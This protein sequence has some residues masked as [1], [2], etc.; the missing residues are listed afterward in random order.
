MS[1]TTHPDAVGRL[2]AAPQL[3]A[4]A[5]TLADKR[6]ATGS[7]LWGSSVAAVVAA[8]RQKL[9]RPIVLVC[10]HLDEADDLADDVELFLGTRPDVVP[11]LE[12]GGSLGRVSEEQ[13]SNRLKLV[14]RLAAGVG[15]T[16]ASPSSA[17]AKER[18]TQVS[19][20]LV[21]PIQALMQAVPAKSE[22]GNLVRTLKV[23]DELESE[24]LIVWLAD[25]GYQRLDQVEVPGDF[26]VRGGIVDVYLPGEF[27]GEAEGEEDQLGLPIRIDFFGDQIESIR[28]FNMETLGSGRQLPS[29]R[30]MD[31]KG[32]IDSVDSVNLLSYLPEESV[33]I[34]WEPLEIAEQA[35]SYFERLPEVKGI[36]TLNAVLKNAE[37]F[38]RLELSQ[39][40][41]GSVTLTLLG[42]EAAPHFDLPVRSLQ[43][44]E[45]E[46]K[47]AIGELAELAKSH[48][49]TVFCENEGEAK[50]FGELIDQDAPGLGE[51]L[52][53]AVGYLHRG[54]VWESTG[55][56]PVPREKPI[57]LVGH[58]ELFHR[59]EM[60]RRVKRVIASRP[61]DSF[62][63]LKDGD[64]VVHVAHGIARFM[65]MRTIN[66]DGQNEEY[67]T[68]RFAENATLHVPAARIN[69]VQ[70]YI[71]GFHGHPQLSRLGSGVWEKQKAKVS[72]AVM[73]MAAELLEVQAA[74]AA[75]QGLP[76][77][78]DTEWQ[79]EFEA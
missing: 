76:Y 63:D 42:K 66:K 77:P 30:V 49:V 11:A 37:R 28:T 51:Q 68:L 53:V 21:S 24:K 14:S 12:L 9:G 20:L 27:E 44:F 55:E 33:V 47:K 31:L 40:D 43:K 5:E 17:P 46:A 4:L 57:A 64:Y 19:P 56:K 75:E 78:P 52:T 58:H 48:D 15:A 32:Q 70:K 7:G 36:Y 50:R 18:A 60:R 73:D 62:L 67:L 2:V 45:T 1:E 13:V 25:H 65:G 10:G 71:G 34:L 3:A 61:V 29:V 26:A 54:F 59:Y 38:A 35:K 6:I 23:G 69:L 74:R 41:Q 79:K 16:P 39:F 22:L 72:E 8:V